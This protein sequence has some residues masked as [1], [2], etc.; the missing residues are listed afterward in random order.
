M[1]NLGT[2]HKFRYSQTRDDTQKQVRVLSW[3]SVQKRKGQL[4]VAHQVFF[5]FLFYFVLFLFLF[6]ILT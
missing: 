2:L 4:K 6:Y 5:Y 1:N 3:R